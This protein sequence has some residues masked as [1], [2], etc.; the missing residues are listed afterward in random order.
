[1]AFYSSGSNVP[2]LADFKQTF[3]WKT[4]TYSSGNYTNMVM[5]GPTKVEPNVTNFWLALD[6]IVPLPVEVYDYTRESI[7][8]DVTL[9][10]CVVGNE[11]MSK[12]QSPTYSTCTCRYIVPRDD[13]T[14]V[15]VTINR[16]GVH[17]LCASNFST[18]TIMELSYDYWS[19]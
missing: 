9:R 2:S 13:K 1:M 16:Y 19:E 4:F 8:K 10:M 11:F 14:Q 15:P 7:S 6:E 3:K 12:Y 17:N 18:Q 5:S